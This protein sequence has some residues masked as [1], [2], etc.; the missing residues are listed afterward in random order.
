MSIDDILD[1]ALSETGVD[2]RQFSQAALFMDTGRSSTFTGLIAKG[3]FNELALISSIRNAMDNGLVSTRY[4]DNLLYVAENDFSFSVLE[5]GILVLG[6]GEAIRAVIDV[7]RGD[8]ERVSGELVEAFNDLG[9]GLLRVQAAIPEDLAGKYLP[10]LI[11][12]FPFLGEV[13]SGEGDSGLLGPVEGLR[14]LEFAGLALAQNGQIFILRI[15]LEFANQESAEA[16]SGLLGGLITLASSF[17]PDPALTELL[18]KLEVTRDDAQVS[19]RLEIDGPELADLISSLTTITQSEGGTI[20][21]PLI[22]AAPIAALGDEFPIM[23]TSFHVQLG[24]EVDYSSTPPTSGDHWERWADCG[25]YPEG[26]PDETITHNLE[27]GNIVVSYN[28]SL[29]SQIDRLQAVIDNIELSAGWVVTRYYDEIP[30][31]QIVLSAWGR[32]IRLAGID[33]ES[34]EAFFLTYVGQLGPERIPC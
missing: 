30:E 34:M 14:D 11:A 16:I 33:Q 12:T 13:L 20:Q 22:R 2:L 28:L 4:K 21:E 18:G 10:F 27:H 31:G 24:Q 1:E 15:N 26:L 9:G 32:M 7:Q 17:S 5:E 19:I 25:F 6:T 8:R 3:N 23:P 29:Q